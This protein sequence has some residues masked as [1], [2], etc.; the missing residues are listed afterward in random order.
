[1]L[2]VL[3]PSRPAAVRAAAASDLGLTYDVRRSRSEGEQVIL[4]LTPRNATG[5]EQRLQ[6]ILAAANPELSRLAGPNPT[7]A[8]LARGCGRHLTK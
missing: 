5:A 4:A 6:D 1:L 7:V 3:W 8:R 2:V